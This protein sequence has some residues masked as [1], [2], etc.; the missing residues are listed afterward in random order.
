MATKAQQ[1]QATLN[2][3]KAISHPLRAAALQILNER[4]ASPAQIARELGEADIPKVS[5]HVKRLV[6]LD[7]A[8]LMDER[9]IRNT[10]EH[11]YRAT[12]RHLVETGEWDDLVDASPELAKHLV[13][14][15]MQAILDDFIASAKAEMIGSD[16][17]FHLTRTPMVVDAQGLQEGMEI[18]ERARMEMIEVERRAA[19]R[20]SKTGDVGVYICSCQG[21]FQIPAPGGATPSA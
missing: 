20:R 9:K 13:G 21:C 10:I 7:C 3:L 16:R 19:E 14:E 2:R 11:F 18:Q 12:D 4:I 5:Y 15:Y 6:E 8:E 1:R 17:N